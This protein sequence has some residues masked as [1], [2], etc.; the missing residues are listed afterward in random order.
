MGNIMNKGNNNAEYTPAGWDTMSLQKKEIM[1]TRSILA[2]TEELYEMNDTEGLKV[3][4]QNLKSLSGWLNT[5]TKLLSQKLEIIGRMK[6]LLEHMNSKGIDEEFSENIGNIASLT[7][8]FL[9]DESEEDLDDYRFSQA[10]SNV[11]AMMEKEQADFETA[12]EAEQK[13]A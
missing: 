7:T 13:T 6:S 4:A 8:D 10:Y 12:W 9:V 3:L 1:A 5:R 2:V 11:K